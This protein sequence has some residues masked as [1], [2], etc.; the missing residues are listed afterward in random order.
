MSG[1]VVVPILFLKFS[2]STTAFSKCSV[3][4]LPSGA[5]KCVMV[6]IL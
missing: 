5:S 2:K 6:L 4:S 3:T 1:V